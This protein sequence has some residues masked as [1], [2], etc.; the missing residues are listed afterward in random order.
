MLELGALFMRTESELIL[1]S[2]RVVPARLLQAG[3]TFKH[4][5]WP[6]AAQELCSHFKTN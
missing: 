5:S 6:E 4:P 2:R 3:F 1:K